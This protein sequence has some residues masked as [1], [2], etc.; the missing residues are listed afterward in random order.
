MHRHTRQHLAKMVEQTLRDTG[1]LDAVKDGIAL[2]IRHDF[3]IPDMSGNDYA[4]M[5]QRFGWDGMCRSSARLVERHVRERLL[6]PEP[7]YTDP[8]VCFL[9]AALTGPGMWSAIARRLLPTV[10]EYRAKIDATADRWVVVRSV[11]M[12]DDLEDY[13]PG[14]EPA[15]VTDYT[16]PFVEAVKVLRERLTLMVNDGSNV[17]DLEFVEVEGER[18]VLE[19]VSKVT[20]HAYRFEAVRN[21]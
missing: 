1:S 2:D 3:G 15:P 5:L 7:D 18:A 17:R 16:L 12:R 14:G 19:Y 9:N 4:A 6:P 11:W 8:A 10:E 21:P 13:Y 20:G